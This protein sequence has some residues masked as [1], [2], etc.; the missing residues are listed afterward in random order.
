MRSTKT[1]ISDTVDRLPNAAS[2]SMVSLHSPLI[3]NGMLKQ[4]NIS[5]QSFHAFTHFK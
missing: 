1:S 2:I 3:Q 4:V 5:V